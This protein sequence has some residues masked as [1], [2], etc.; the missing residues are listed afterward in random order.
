MADADCIDM[1]SQERATAIMKLAEASK[2]YR[3]GYKMV[4]WW[5]VKTVEL[6]VKT[7]V[8]KRYL[9]EMLESF[10]A[11]VREKNIFDWHVEQFGLRWMEKTLKQAEELL[12]YISS[13]NYKVG[14]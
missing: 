11:W 7:E 5:S 12:H 13:V 4:I 14:I 1:L 8:A 9:K 2:M 3:L 10:I 6:H